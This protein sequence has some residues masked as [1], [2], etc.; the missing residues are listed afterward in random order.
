MIAVKKTASAYT[1]AVFDN[2]GMLQAAE[3][4]I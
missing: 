3:T 1:K 4:D 2:K